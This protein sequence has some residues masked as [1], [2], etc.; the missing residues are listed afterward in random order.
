MK[1]LNQY[2]ALCNK[3][4]NESYSEKSLLVRPQFFYLYKCY[5]KAVSVKLFLY[6]Y[7]F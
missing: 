6:L 7:G 5:E 2:T 3:Y 1:G 4:L